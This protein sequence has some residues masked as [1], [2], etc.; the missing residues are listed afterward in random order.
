VQ[1]TWSV[2]AGV[3][4]DVAIPLGDRAHWAAHDLVGMA[5][6]GIGRIGDRGALDLDLEEGTSP[7]A[8]RDAR[9]GSE[10]T[11]ASEGDPLDETTPVDNLE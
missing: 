5:V 11:S 3:T 1:R 4:N 7:G 10:V 6:P 8:S 9:D 2:A